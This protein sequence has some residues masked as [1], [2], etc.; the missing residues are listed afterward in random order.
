[1]LPVHSFPTRRSS[2]LNPGDAPMSYATLRD[3]Q[4]RGENVALADIAAHYGTPCYVY[5]R[6]AISANFLAYR[7]AGIP[8]PLLVCYAVKANRSEEHT[9][10][11]QSRENL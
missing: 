1:H 11:L 2:D 4:L 9:S 3:G 8:Q 10:E 5:S 7:N 6:A